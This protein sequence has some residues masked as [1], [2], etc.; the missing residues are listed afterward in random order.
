MR[1][2]SDRRKKAKRVKRLRKGNKEAHVLTLSLRVLG[3]KTDDDKW[4]AHCLETDLV[5]Y[6]SSFE[7][8]I[9]DLKELTEMQVS[10]AVYKNQPSLL[11]RPAS[12]DIHETY[13]AL[14]RK[15]LLHYYIDRQI[16]PKREVGSI[17]LPSRPTRADF[18][19][20]CA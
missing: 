18:N 3:Y 10:F 8:A 20:V 17:P 6:G 1:N 13:N 16:D 14:L 12:P 7:L 15:T 2:A 5:G 11:D 9:N 4:A 19:L